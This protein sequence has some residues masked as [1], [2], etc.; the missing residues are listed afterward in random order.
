MAEPRPFFAWPGSR[1][2]A[3]TL[4]LGIVSTLWW[5]SLYHGANAITECREYRVRLHLEF[6]LLVPFVPAAVL[7]YLSLYLVLWL[8]PFVLRSR[9]E[10]QGLALTLM[11]VTA[12][13]FGGFLLFPADSAYPHPGNLGGWT[14]L[15]AFAKDMSLPHNFLPSLHVAMCGACLFAYE[16]KATALG[17]WMLRSWLAGIALSTLLIHEHYLVDVAAGWL[18]GWAAVRSIYVRWQC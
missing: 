12:V 4:L 5:V 10:A 14:K 16:G 2:M 7:L 9:K 17:R 8:A 18:L 3:Y 15:V 1:H 11:A 6:E 13:G